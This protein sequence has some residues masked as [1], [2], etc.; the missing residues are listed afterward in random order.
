MKRK[1]DS[2]ENIATNKISSAEH[3]EKERQQQQNSG[4]TETQ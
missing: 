2:E 3:S 4:I 1:N